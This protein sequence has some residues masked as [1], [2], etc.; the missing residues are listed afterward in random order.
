MAQ[1]AWMTLLFLLCGTVALWG[2]GAG[3]GG[4]QAG[5]GNTPAGGGGGNQPNRPSQP[6]RDQQRPQQDPFG[7]G[8]QQMPEFERPIYLSGNVVLEDGT[9]P[10]EPVIIERVC[11]GRSFPEGNTNNK[12][13]FSIHLGG[14][15]SL[16]VM[17]ASVGSPNANTAF[18]N[19]SMQRS[20]NTL[21]RVD[22]TGCELRAVLSGFTS[23]SVSLGRR[24]VFD[25]PKVGTMVLRRVGGVEGTSISFTSLAAPKKAKQQ[26][27][28][29]VK[30]VRKDKPNFKKA[31][32][33]LEK[34][35]EEY[36][37]FAS[38]WF[39][40]GQVRLMLED[41]AG[42]RE[43][44][45]KAL[46]VDAKYINPYDPLIRMSLNTGRWEEGKKLASQA[47]QL[48]PHL[49]EIQYFHAI[50]SF[51]LGNL[52]DAERSALA[53]RETPEGKNLGGNYHLLGMILA[54]KGQ[55]A[56][57]AEQYRTY[58]ASYPDTPAADRVRQQLTEWEALGVI[59]AVVV[60]AAG[61]R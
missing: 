21:G 55:F 16:A 54:K 14:N 4:G 38:A 5:G 32:D 7:G 37:E 59:E 53:V 28:S 43:A 60:P 10:P 25:D 3:G 47:L 13:Y 50:A 8:N 29:A 11:D 46:E 39:L 15:T 58:L 22:L 35:L 42:A 51:E 9:P 30:E 23:D 34:A 36:P 33:Q 31:S 26:F 56:P 27:E 49:T 2:Q 57:A 19:N 24:S 52:E 12:G 41:D 44:F 48:N 6:S 40:M 18:G 61:A 45:E 20:G 1:R 17:D